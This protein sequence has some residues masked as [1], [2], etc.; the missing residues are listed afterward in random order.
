MAETQADI[1][2]LLLAGGAGR[3]MGGVDK[4]LQIL[5]GRPLAVHVLQR[6]RPQVSSV[7]ISAN[8]HLDRYAALGHPVLADPRFD[9]EYQGPLAGMLAGLRACPGEWLQCVPC[10]VPQ[11]P[12]D[13]CQRLVASLAPGVQAVWPLTQDAGQA[14]SQ[15]AFALLHRSLA[16]S[17]ERYLASGERRVES[18]LRAQT[19]I[20]ADFSLPGDAAAFANLNTLADLSPPS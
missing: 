8:R 17:L 16:S 2:G 9:G 11:L 20:Q 6:I 18:W 13:L 7:F 1:T 14:R 15:P 12:L 5:D 19:H 3:R 10:D 4:G